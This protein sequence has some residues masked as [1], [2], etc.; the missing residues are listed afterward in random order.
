MTLIILLWVKGKRE[1]GEIKDVI[2]V[3]VQGFHKIDV[4]PE[5][6]TE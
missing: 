3:A 4:P 1:L 5:L 2:S 6:N